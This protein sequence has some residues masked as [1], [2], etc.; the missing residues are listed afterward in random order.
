M[1][2][3]VLIFILSL[4]LEL[5]PLVFAVDPE[6]ELSKLSSEEIDEV[7]GNFL[8]SGE[9]ED[10]DLLQYFLNE[11]LSRSDTEPDPELLRGVFRKLFKSNTQ[12]PDSIIVSYILSGDKDSLQQN[13]QYWREQRDQASYKNGEAW[14]SAHFYY[15]L[16]SIGVLFIEEV[17]VLKKLVD[18][19]DVDAFHQIPTLVDEF[20]RVRDEIVPQDEKAKEELLVLGR[21]GEVLERVR[22]PLAVA[23][24]NFYPL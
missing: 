16:I 19:E 17:D 6:I 13:A 5:P 14:R 9:S 23:I 20:V 7:L 12:G 18:K 21:S 22:E 8:E 10:P 11:R 4:Q 15:L 3:P 24:I 1:F 2:R